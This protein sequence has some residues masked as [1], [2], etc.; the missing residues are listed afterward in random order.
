M[1]HS[2]RT[3]LGNLQKGTTF[4]LS[5]HSHRAISCNNR[6]GV[7]WQTLS[8]NVP[9]SQMSCAGEL[10]CVQMLHLHHSALRL[11]NLR[12]RYSGAYVFVRILKRNFYFRIIVEYFLWV[13]FSSFNNVKSLQ[14]SFLVSQII[15]FFKADRFLSLLSVEPA[16]LKKVH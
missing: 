4:T 9:Q 2:H 16:L 7:S 10:S 14:I 1:T 15:E 3:S 6:V 5:P 8:D 12:I 11:G 13:S